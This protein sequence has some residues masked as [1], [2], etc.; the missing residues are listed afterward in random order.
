MTIYIPTNEIIYTYEDY[1]LSIN[2]GVGLHLSQGATSLTMNI[3]GFDNGI[4]TLTFLELYGGVNKIRSIQYD[5]STTTTLSVNN[6][7]S[8]TD[9]TQTSDLTPNSL[10][11]NG[12]TNAVII[13]ANPS[14]GNPS[15]I[16][17]TDNT[18]LA[19]GLEVG[20]LYSADITAYPTIVKSTLSPSTLTIDNAVGNISTITSNTLEMNDTVATNGI[21]VSNNITLGEPFISMRSSGGYTNYLNWGGIVADRHY[22]YTFDNNERFFKQQNP[23]SF[24]YTELGDGAYIEANFPFVF[25][26]TG[27]VL[28]LYDPSTY[29]DDLGYAGWSCIISNYTVGTLN[30]DI[31]SASSWYSHSSGGR[32][33]NPITINKW[34]TCRITLCYSS[35]DTQYIWAVSQF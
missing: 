7:I 21:T 22:C 25:T 1:S 2:P 10:Q 6:T 8:I 3:N 12:T 17:A 4:Q 28:K 26:Q 9:G 30:I 34:V 33:S 20:Q 35:L 31:A 15:C 29:L 19:T 13:Q 5:S 14:P 11:L 32:Q 18:T 24:K 27:N 23:F 16:T